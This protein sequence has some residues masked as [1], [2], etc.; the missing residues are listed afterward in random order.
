MKKNTL[1]A[2]VMVNSVMLSASAFAAPSTGGE[3]FKANCSVCHPHGGNIMRPDKPLKGIRNPERIISQIRSG[4]GGMPSFDVKTISD[5]D[6]K[7]LAEYIM[8]TFKK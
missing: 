5:V 6:A 3:I 4:G 7:Q 1:M 8:K 2:I